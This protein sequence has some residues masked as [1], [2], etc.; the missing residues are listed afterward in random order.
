MPRKKRVSSEVASEASE[1][2]MS[3]SVRVVRFSNIVT[4]F[5]DCRR[6][7]DWRIDLLDTHES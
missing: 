7:L 5:S 2:V 3:H 4:C 1:K 6:D